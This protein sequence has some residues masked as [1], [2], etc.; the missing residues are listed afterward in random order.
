MSLCLKHHI[1]GRVAHRCTASFVP[2]SG[3]RIPLTVSSALR[4]FDSNLKAF[5]SV[6]DY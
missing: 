3:A 2:I 4:R 5:K 1:V 6:T